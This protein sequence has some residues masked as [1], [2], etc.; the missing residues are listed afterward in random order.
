MFLSLEVRSSAKNNYHLPLKHRRNQQLST[1]SRL[2]TFVPAS[3]LRAGH[4]R[5]LQNAWSRGCRPAFA[6]V[7]LALLVLLVPVILQAEVDSGQYLIVGEV[8]EFLQSSGDG[9]LASLY[10]VELF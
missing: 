3:S 1:D 6:Q 7:G 9:L 2:F 5:P 4:A 10:T 8:D